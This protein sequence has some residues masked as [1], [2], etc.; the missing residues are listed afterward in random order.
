MYNQQHLTN[1]QVLTLA[2]ESIG[3]LVRIPQ[4]AAFQR[5]KAGFAE[6]KGF[7]SGILAVREMLDMADKSGDSLSLWINRNFDKYAK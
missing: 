5:F 4:V 7:E 3:G 1:E 2:K 6:K